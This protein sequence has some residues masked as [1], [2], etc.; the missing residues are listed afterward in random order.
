MSKWDWD[1]L[2]QEMVEAIGR[3]LSVSEWARDRGVPGRTARD[4]IF[5]IEG[6]D[7]E[8]TVALEKARHEAIAG[9]GQA[10]LEN[11]EKSLDEQVIGEIPVVQG[12]LEDP[13]IQA[14]LAKG[15]VN[16]KIWEP[17]K[18]V[19]N[20]WGSNLQ[21]KVWLDYVGNKVTPEQYREMIREG[22]Q[23]VADSIPV[24]MD[25]EPEKTGYM[26]EVS[27]FDIHVGKLGWGEEVGEDYDSKIALERAKGAVIDLVS[28]SV[29]AY[30]PEQF[31]WPV[32][33]DLLHA[34]GVD[35]GTTKGT[36]MD[37]DS[38]YLKM[39]RLAW[40]FNA[41]AITTL[42]QIAPVYVPVIP[43]NHDRISAFQVGEVLAAM[44]EGHPHVE[45][46][47]RACLRKYYLWGNSL[48]GFTHGDSEYHKDLPLIMADEVPEM[49][50][51]SDVRE[52]HI[53][54]RHNK[55]QTKW[56]THDQYRTIG[57]RILP[58]LTGQDLYHYQHGFRHVP[59]AEAWVW[60]R[61]M[62]NVANFTHFHKPPK[63]RALGGAE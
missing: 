10:Q 13:K 58:S 50:A 44:F 52:W 30:P 54:H 17:T 49:W 14:L 32:G 39:F 16:L 3:G 31:V 9:R 24:L 43:G 60:H 29:A 63:T 34:D 19:V 42:S 48:L 45:I 4:R 46:D 55:K 1:E 11:R 23:E 6:R 5:K 2:E 18:C 47:N 61:E 20:Q 33:N 35:G 38:R 51:K 40:Q 15:E 56:V 53:G 12:D 7:D 36:R 41:W 25:Y 26:I 59:Q 27:P 62:A 8:M 28:R 57:V 21:A 22:V 37:L